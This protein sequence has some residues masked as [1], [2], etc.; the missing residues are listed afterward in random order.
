MSIYAALQPTCPH[1]PSG[2]PRRTRRLKMLEELLSMRG[3]SKV[4]GAA[5]WWHER[6]M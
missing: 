1:C 6:V 5:A 3:G 4:C 2:A